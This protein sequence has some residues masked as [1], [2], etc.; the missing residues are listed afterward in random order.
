M[1]VNLAA[2]ELAFRVLQLGVI[3]F[4][5]MRAKNLDSLSLSYESVSG[6]ETSILTVVFLARLVL[7]SGR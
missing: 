3:R 7:R 4:V 5:I 1:V 6:F 2:D